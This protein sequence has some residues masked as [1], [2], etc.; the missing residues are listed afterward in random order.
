MEPTASP[1]TPARPAQIR[2]SEEDAL[3]IQLTRPKA[4]PRRLDPAREESDADA[5]TQQLPR[6]KAKP[7][8]AEPSRD[9]SPPPSVARRPEAVSNNRRP[10][11]QAETSQRRSHNVE[12]TVSPD[13][14]LDYDEP[15]LPPI[16]APRAE[17]TVMPRD[18]APPK[19]DFEA[20][21][22]RASKKG[23]SAMGVVP[24]LRTLEG[25]AKGI[26][27]WK[28]IA[29]EAQR[30]EKSQEE[31]ES[32]EEEGDDLESEDGYPLQMESEVAPHLQL[33]GAD[34]IPLQLNVE[35]DGLD[36]LEESEQD[37]ARTQANRPCQPAPRKPPARRPDPEPRKEKPKFVAG[38]VPAGREKVRNV[39]TPLVSERRS[40][41]S[42]RP[43]SQ[44][45][46]PPPISSPLAEYSPLFDASSPPPPPAKRKRQVTA[47]SAK[48]LRLAEKRAEMERLIDEHDT[49]VREMFHLLHFKTMIVGYAPSE[50]KKETSKVWTD[51]SPAEISCNRR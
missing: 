32:Q 9:E 17:T 24:P 5:P 37:P 49:V 45:L 42:S 12:R 7:R 43:A 44:R 11:V 19:R 18:R 4:K 50:A 46:P 1:P 35:Y 33:Q 23:G 21:L 36:E 41:T 3:T 38:K 20:Y 25:L 22:K 51:V 27:R 14:T 28:K 40:S 31:E 16:L 47:P 48:A 34:T 15:S 30:E 2:R 13:F 6:P 29:M 10:E 39:A 8:M 26:N